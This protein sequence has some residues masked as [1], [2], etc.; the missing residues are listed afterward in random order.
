VDRSAHERA[1]DDGAPHEGA[2]ERVPLEP[3]DAGPEPE[4]RV[5][6]VLVLDAPDPLDRARERQARPLEQELPRQQRPVQLASGEGALGHRAT[7]PTR[8]L[9]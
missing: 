9:M 7:L 5:R 8:G 1:L 2:I 6:G 3:L 4:V